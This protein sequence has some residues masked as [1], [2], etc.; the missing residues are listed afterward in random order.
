MTS[1]RAYRTALPTSVAV[2]E[3]QRLAGTQ[4]D[5]PC[6]EALLSAIASNDALAEPALAI[7]SGRRLV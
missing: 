6:V 1:A 5:A 4:F 3:L 7:A 2:A